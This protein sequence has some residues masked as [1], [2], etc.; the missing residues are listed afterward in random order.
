MNS[1]IEGMRYVLRG[2]SLLKTPGLKR[3]IL[4]PILFNLMLFV[5]LFY[6]IYHYLLPY[7]YYYLD[8]LPSWLSILSGVF[9]V[10]FIICFFLFFV[11]MFHIVFNLIASPFNS[12]L[13]EKVQK[14]MYQQAIPEQSLWLMTK[15]TL[16]RQAQFLAYFLPRFTGMVVLFFVP[17][18]QPVYP[19]LWFA[20]SAWMLSVQ[21]QDFVYDNNLF[22]FSL[23][24]QHIARHKMHALGFGTL[25]NLAC[26]IPIINILIMPAAVI[27]S[28][29]MYHEQE[30]KGRQLV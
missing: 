1:F 12:L 9:F 25:I 6:L 24:R 10:I 8:K 18:I 15:R 2:L 11:L 26:A 21:Y 27:G 28:V 7:A 17:L 30:H 13:A 22:D 4:M 29:L 5:G 23:M 20:F 3:F 14:I 19:F 16:K